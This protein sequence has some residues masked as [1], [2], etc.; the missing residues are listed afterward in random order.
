[1]SECN[2]KCRRH[3]VS[4]SCAKHS[5]KQQLDTSGNR[6]PQLGEDGSRRLASERRSP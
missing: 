4:P 1:M 3:A 6:L 5:P 2:G